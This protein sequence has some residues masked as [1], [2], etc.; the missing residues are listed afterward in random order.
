MLMPG[1]A[2]HPCALVDEAGSSMTPKL[3]A[4]PIARRERCIRPTERVKCSAGDVDP[5][6]ASLAGA[7][8]G[9]VARSQLLDAGIDRKAIEVRLKRN[10]LHRLHAGVYAV[11]HPV[12]GT[13][14][15]WSAAVLAG[16]QDAVL[17]HRAA[18]QL[19]EL[20]PWTTLFVEVTRPRSSRG[21][22]RIKFHRATVPADERTVVD[23]IP[24]T[25]MPRTILD[26]GS[27]LD[28]RLLERAI[29]EAEVLGLTDPLSVPDLLVRHRGRRGPAVLRA[30]FGDR[31]A[32]RGVTANTF[33]ALFAGLVDEYALPTPRF[34]AELAIRGRFFKVDAMWEAQKVI[35]ELDGRAAHGTQSAFEN[36]RQRDRLLLLA[37][38]RIVRITWLQLRDTPEVIAADLRE[39]L[40]RPTASTLSA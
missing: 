26:L 35:V 24:V 9:I 16:G 38:W 34:N 7:Q 4:P 39:L 19:W 15:R 13:R 1:S 14:G 8:H 18:G 3:L 6:I 33:E 40:G 17:S 37:G 29:N 10:R 21:R 2:R 36:D 20:L 5:V 32:S 25:S 31:E 30:I 27:V 12:I 22:S 28:R 23:G 11:G